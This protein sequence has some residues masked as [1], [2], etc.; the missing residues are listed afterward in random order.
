MNSK[1]KKTNTKNS[2]KTDTTN[3]SKESI[4]AQ[5]MSKRT[6]V[7]RKK[8]LEIKVLRFCIE[9]SLVI[10]FIIGFFAIVTRT[11]KDLS[12]P[13]LLLSIFFSVIFLAFTKRDLKSEFHFLLSTACMFI[14]IASFISY[15]PF[16]LGYLNISAQMLKSIV[17]II[18]ELV[19]LFSMIVIL[20]ALYFAFSF[21][22]L[23]K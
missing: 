6:F 9:Y 10:A 20:P 1:N 17:T 3:K 15:L 7:Q 21:V 2:K 13:I 16:I 11:F 8:E 5:V 19:I 12:L 22:F 23:K 14:I 18:T 4:N